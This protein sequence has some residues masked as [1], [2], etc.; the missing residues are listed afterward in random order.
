MT[1]ISEFTDILKDHINST[2]IYSDEPLANHTYIK[3]GGPADIL[4]ETKTKDQL[5]TVYQLAHRHHIP[6]FILGGGSNLLISDRGI[7]GLVIKNRADALKIAKFHGDIKAKKLHVDQ[8]VLEA[9]SGVITNHLVR[10]SID[11]GL[12][13]LQFF[14]GL[15]GTVGG[16]IYNNS[17]YKH[18]LIGN[19]VHQVQVLDHQGHLK[20]YTQPDLKFRYDYSILQQTKELILSAS[21]LLK[22]GDKQKLW[23]QATSYAKARAQTQPLSLP[24]SGCIFKNLTP[25][26]A[27]QAGLKPDQTS[28]GFLIDQA[29]LKDTQIGQVKVSPI[30]ANFFVNLG[31][32][33]ASELKQLINLVQ[34]K[35]KSKYHITLEPEVFFVGEEV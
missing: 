25:D 32:G 21:F 10:Y 17:H 18:Q 1:S 3:I 26:Q 5:I 2:Q 11:N 22:G 33:T 30:H 8:A 34:D 28:A 16:A 29:G 20:T 9:G 23:D 7:R 6:V 27:K 12:E 15:P 24:S 35:I 31:G 4:V 13:G 14:L 19:F